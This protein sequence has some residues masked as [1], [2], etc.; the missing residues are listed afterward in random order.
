MT[1]QPELDHY[2]TDTRVVG[3]V[4]FVHGPF[5]Y[6]DTKVSYL[7]GLPATDVNIAVIPHVVE[8]SNDIKNLPLLKR[9]CFYENEVFLIHSR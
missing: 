4:I 6:P 7:L 5:E 1:L 8:S 9:K 2:I 3:T